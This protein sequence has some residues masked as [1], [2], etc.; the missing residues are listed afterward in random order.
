MPHVQKKKKV[1]LENSSPWSA[2]GDHPR[3]RGT[4]RTGP[5][6]RLPV[7]VS[8]ETATARAAPAPASGSHDGGRA[9]C[10][11]ALCARHHRRARAAAAGTWLFSSRLFSRG[12]GPREIDLSASE[13]LLH[14]PGHSPIER[15]GS[16]LALAVSGSIDGRRKGACGSGGR[17]RG[18]RRRTGRERGPRCTAQGKRRVSPSASFV[19]ATL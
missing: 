14:T 3:P 9:R 13:S 1:G 15:G 7:H 11:M 8:R 6:P 17:R 18:A 16:I 10:S 19:P 12:D 5:R 2:N 4:L